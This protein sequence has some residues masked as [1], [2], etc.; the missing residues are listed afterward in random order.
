MSA[1]WKGV[2]TLNDNPW[3]KPRTREPSLRIPHLKHTAPPDESGMSR[4]V[5]HTTTPAAQPDTEPVTSSRRGLPIQEQPHSAVLWVVGAHGGAGESTLAALDPTW[6][7][8]Q[9]AWPLIDPTPRCV[10][11][12]RTNL[13]G[14]LAAQAALTQWA[15]PATRPPVELVGL[16]LLADAPGKTP[17][18][19]RDLAALVAGGAPATWHVPWVEAWRTDPV[20]FATAPSAVTRAVAALRQLLASSRPPPM[21]A[22]V[23]LDHPDPDPVPHATAVK[24]G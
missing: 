1:T 18:P 16:V 7:P 23:A 19:L 13:S 21:V 5:P 14:L 15:S 22:D 8:A 24:E 10:L 2:G 20:D 9:H 4:D 11:T 6:R 12:A 17:K 3:L